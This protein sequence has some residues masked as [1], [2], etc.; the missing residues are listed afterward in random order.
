MTADP[1]CALLTPPADPS[2]RT[3]LK[4]MDN[5]SQEI[6]DE[7]DTTLTQ[8]TTTTTTKIP[9]G[10]KS[11]KGLDTLVNQH[12]VSHHHQSQSTTPSDGN[13]S[14]QEDQTGADSGL[15]V[16]G[17][18][19]MTNKTQS[20]FATFR[21]PP[22]S[23]SSSAAKDLSSLAFSKLPGQQKNDNGSPSGGE[24]SG[25]PSNSSLASTR[26]SAGPGT[27]SS[28][29]GYHISTTTITTKKR[30]VRRPTFEPRSSRLDPEALT[31]NQDPFR[32]FHTLFWIVM[33]AYGVITFDEEWTRVGKAFGGTL[34]SSFSQDAIM[35]AVSD[36]GLVL[37]TGVA[38]L[39]IKI[40]AKGWIRYQ[41]VGMVVQHCV[42]LLFL[43][44]AIAW[45]IWRD[46]PWVQSGFFTLHAITM[47]MKIHS[48]IAYNGELSE[49]LILLKKAEQAYAQHK[50]DDAM[51]AD[52]HN[53][54]DD[55][56][57]DTEAD[58]SSES[59]SP[60]QGS[61]SPNDTTTDSDQDLTAHRHHRLASEAAAALLQEPATLNSNVLAAE[62]E[63]LRS[64]LKCQNGEL[65][66]ANVTI[67]N[68][69][70]YLIVPSLIYEL[71]YPRTTKIRP[72]YVFEKSVATLGTFTLLYLTTEH[73]IYPV[74]F[75]PTISPL[76]ALVLLLIPFMMN[77]LMIFYIIFECICNAFAELSRFADR[78]FYEDWWNCVSFDEWA[79]KWNKPVH[80]FLLRHVY[81]SSIESFHLSKSNAALAT[82]F[83]SSCVH[84]LV[85]M[86]VTRK[87]RLYLFVLQMF[88]LPLIW[89]GNNK[90]VREKPRLANALFW[91]GMFCGP[92]L[93][94]VAYCYA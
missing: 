20:T 56:P 65:W 55:Q 71:Q 49:K 62:I 8:T 93:L 87:V 70:D 7:E 77:Y 46:W 92:P 67:A 21:A 32:G 94:G 42:Q 68:F 45:T 12:S 76:R 74:V 72:M 41:N 85:M 43:L 58:T 73:Y 3:L 38:F 35:L 27:P 75:D 26:S 40:I 90:T 59:S 39:L 83:L 47:L 16:E 54:T 18:T 14:E 44:V 9:K 57:H 63:E 84:E 30:K 28:T 22:T 6:V 5:H 33:G 36:F 50:K 23:L 19:T 81:D 24:L 15:P 52:D 69:V 79:R 1:D 88:Q 11:L 53:T 48:Y 89:M 37:S 4:D 17:D 10:L 25:S 80:H 78:N 86:V 51:T 31:K 2:P 61:P 60:L 91:L 34:F 66:P 82:F 13:G 64:D 29:E